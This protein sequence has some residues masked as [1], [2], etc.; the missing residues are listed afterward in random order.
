MPIKS[1]LVIIGFLMLIF[2]ACVAPE[3]RDDQSARIDAEVDAALEVHS[4]T[5][6]IRPATAPRSVLAELVCAEGCRE[7]TLE[8]GITEESR[9]LVSKSPAAIVR[10][11]Q[12]VSVSLHRT[13][14]DDRA[15]F[16][17]LMELDDGGLAA[18]QARAHPMLLA[19]NYFEGTAIGSTPFSAAGRFFPLGYFDEL[20]DARNASSIF[21]TLPLN[22]FSGAID[23]AIP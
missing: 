4:A 15:K 10:L 9:Y 11:D 22:D 19:V 18:L 20:E 3:D 7:V 16:V 6:E 8:T 13:D 23:T 1:T 12:I 21:S 2:T 17:V 14:D 5:A